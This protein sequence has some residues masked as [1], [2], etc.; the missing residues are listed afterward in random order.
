MSTAIKLR[1]E[2]AKSRSQDIRI[3][4]ATFLYVSES[5]P[6]IYVDLG[7]VLENMIRGP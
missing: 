5:N 3:F 4:P 2:G 6:A 7:N 1:L